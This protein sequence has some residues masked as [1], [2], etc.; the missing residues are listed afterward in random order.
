VKAYSVERFKITNYFTWNMRIE[1]LLKRNGLFSMVDGLDPNPT[2]TNH[3][4][5]HAWFLC[6]NKTWSYIFQHHGN[7]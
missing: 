3:V 2:N 1:M 7:V 4:T 5:L 6:D